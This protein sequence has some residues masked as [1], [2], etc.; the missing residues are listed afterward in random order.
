M[1][2]DTRNNPLSATP[3]RSLLNA[4][5]TW[6]TADGDWSVALSGTNL[7][8]KEYYINKFYKLNLGQGTIEGQPG[9]PLEWALTVRRV[10]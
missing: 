6:D 10:F 8:D 2:Y 9:R 1:F 7:T 5:L 4:R 3:G